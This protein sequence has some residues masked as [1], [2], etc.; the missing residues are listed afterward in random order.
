MSMGGSGALRAA[1][2]SG[3]NQAKQILLSAGMGYHCETRDEDVAVA[4]AASC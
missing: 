3:R 4:N 1:P 2:V